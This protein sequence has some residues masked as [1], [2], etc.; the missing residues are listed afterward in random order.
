LNT[1]GFRRNYVL[2]YFATDF[3]QSA[4]QTV[5]IAVVRPRRCIVGGGGG[6]LPALQL[7]AARCSWCLRSAHA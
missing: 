5:S 2:A 6:A 1:T 4:T 3:A 7:A